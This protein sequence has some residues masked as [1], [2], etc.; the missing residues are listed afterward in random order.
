MHDLLNGKTAVIFDV[1]GTVVDSLGVW[2]QVDVLLA[3]QLGNVA[4]PSEKLFAFREASLAAHS[5]EENPYE[6]YCGDLGRLYESD[7]DAKTIHAMRFA[8]SRTEIAKHVKLRDGVADVLQ[9]LKRR[10]ITMAVATT[11]KLANVNI[12]CDVN[13]AIRSE[14]NLREIFDFFLT[15][16]DVTA[17]KPDPEV[18][19]KAV[20]KLR[21][22]KKEILVV[23]DS[24][25]GLKAAR[26][27]GLDVLVV[28][29]EHSLQD[30]SYLRRES[31]G[32][33]ESF[34]DVLRDWSKLP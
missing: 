11:T 27:A 20:K 18:Y 28:R 5:A 19:L 32:Y 10:G 12:Y 21:V 31:S 24:V 29:E 14:L 3:A 1:D 16:E 33:A 17:I 15:K 22:D 7:L 13:E 8:I 23:E 4:M 25:T 2:N 30:E 9:F 26:A 34:Q 6:A